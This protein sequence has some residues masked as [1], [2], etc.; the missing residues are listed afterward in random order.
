MGSLIVEVGNVSDS[1]VCLWNPSPTGLSGS[2]LMWCYI[3]GLDVICY[4]LF[5]L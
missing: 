4:A 5:G 3:S 2:A 1:S